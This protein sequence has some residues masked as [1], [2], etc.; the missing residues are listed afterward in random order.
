MMRFLDLLFPPREDELAL[1]GV[2]MDG[3]L[4][5]MR[6]SVVEETVPATTAL[7]SFG[8]PMVRAAIHEAKYHGDERGFALL[9]SALAEYLRDSEEAALSTA[10][11]VPIP[12]GETREKE[13]RFNQVEEIIR[14]AA[15]SIAMDTELMRRTRDTASQVSL[16][17]E[18][19]R[20]NMRGAFSAARP[21]SPSHTYIVIDDVI[22]T[23]ATLQAA[24]DALTEAGAVHI[25]PLALAH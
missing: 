2:S 17:R 4:A 7:F 21:A 3:F 13:R 25:L 6:P 19:R 23:G 14:R 18:A 1:R 12:L 9:A 11:I 22:T 15:L 20:E 16:A 10:C 5:R 8:D 24:I